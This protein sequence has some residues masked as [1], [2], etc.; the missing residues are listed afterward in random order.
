MR[1]F[2]KCLLYLFFLSWASLG[3]LVYAQQGPYHGR[4]IDAETKQPIIDAAVLA[5]WWTESGTYLGIPAP[6][7]VEAFYDAQETLTDIKGNFTISGV[8]EGPIDPQTKLKEP[9]FTIF[10]PGY[11]AVKSRILKPMSAFLPQAV[12]EGLPD[13]I[14]EQDGKMVVELRP[15]KTREERTNNVGGILPIPCRGP[16]DTSRFCMPEDKYRNLLKNIN[17]EE[18]ALGLGLSGMKKGGK[19]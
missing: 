19:P 12:I 1:Y 4:V 2:R 14:S 15:L 3:A 16:N 5:V 18:T 8:I 13:N 10:K 6:H 7:P 9:R 11:E 17:E